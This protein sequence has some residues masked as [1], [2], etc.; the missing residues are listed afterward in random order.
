MEILI[1]VLALAIVIIVSTVGLVTVSL[2]VLSMFESQS[3]NLQPLIDKLK[4]SGDALKATV[5][6][7]PPQ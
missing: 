6:A 1:I 4:T 5:D 2:R 3:S 7:N